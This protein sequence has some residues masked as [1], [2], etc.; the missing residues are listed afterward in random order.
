MTPKEKGQPV[1][2]RKGIHQLVSAWD[3]K[4]R[5]ESQLWTDLHRGLL[6][7][8]KLNAA[9]GFYEPAAAKRLGIPRDRVNHNSLL[10]AAANLQLPSYGLQLLDI[11]AAAVTYVQASTDVAPLPPRLE[12]AITVSEYEAAAIKLA[13]ANAANG[14]ISRSKRARMC[15]QKQRQEQQQ[16]LQQQR[17]GVSAA[18]VAAAVSKVAGAAESSLDPYGAVDARRN[19]CL[20]VATRGMCC[21]NLAL[22]RRCMQHGHIQS[23]VCFVIAI[24][25]L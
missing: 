22:C 24:C 15:K 11:P 8:G 10:S 13:A 4:V 1:F 14:A 23:M 9:L 25:I 19:R 6:T 5:Q 2:F 12:T 18:G 21:D 3:R 16:Q 7:T 17:D 20:T